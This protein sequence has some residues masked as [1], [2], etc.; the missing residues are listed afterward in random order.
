[1]KKTSVLIFLLLVLSQV[2]GQTQGTTTEETAQTMTPTQSAGSLVFDSANFSLAETWLNDNETTENVYFI[3]TTGE[4]GTITNWISNGSLHIKENASVTFDNCRFNG[5]INFY[6]YGEALLLD[7]HAVRIVTDY[8]LV[9]EGLLTLESSTVDYLESRIRVLGSADFLGLNFTGAAYGLRVLADAGSTITSGEI[10]VQDHYTAEPYNLTAKDIRG[11][12]VMFLLD[13][14]HGAQNVQI[15]NVDL[16]GTYYNLLRIGN[17]TI[18]DC[19]LFNH[20]NNYLHLNDCNGTITNFLTVPSDEYDIGIH[21]NGNSHINI[22][23][24]SLDYLVTDRPETSVLRFENTVMHDL[25]MNDFSTVHLTDCQILDTLTRYTVA[26]G[27]CFYDGYEA[28][29]DDVTVGTLTRPG[30]TVNEWQLIIDAESDSEILVRNG[31]HIKQVNGEN[32]TYDQYEGIIDHL[33][34]GRNVTGNL[35]SL[36]LLDSSFQAGCNITYTDSEL[37]GMFVTSNQENFEGISHHHLTRCSN[38][39]YGRWVNTMIFVNLTAV[40]SEFADISIGEF[41]NVDLIRCSMEYLYIDKPG[42]CHTLNLTAQDSLIRCL[43]VEEQTQGTRPRLEFHNVSVVKGWDSTTGSYEPNWWD[44]DFDMFFEDSILGEVAFDVHQIYHEDHIRIEWDA[45]AAPSSVGTYPK[46]GEY[47]VLRYEHANMDYY[48]PNLANLSDYE[49]VAITLALSYCDY[50]IEQGAFYHYIIAVQYDNNNGLW[51]DNDDDIFPAMTALQT[52]I[53]GFTEVIYWT[54]THQVPVN[55]QV[56]TENFF[57]YDGLEVQ[58]EYGT[59]PDFIG[60]TSETV[61]TIY[62]PEHTFIITV[63]GPGTWYVRGRARC[64]RIVFWGSWTSESFEVIDPMTTITTST[65]D[66]DDDDD[67][68]LLSGYLLVPCL[69]GLV[70]LNFLTRRK[71]R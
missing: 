45:S 22:S 44:V 10:L 31:L 65:F 24:S 3:G 70:A 29:D 57:T 15:T 67:G 6:N 21:L 38:D 48:T 58:L 11:I 54:N 59:D 4:W 60:A 50:D 17:L 9:Q 23:G 13:G 43:I 32:I 12:P 71:H 30:T 63:D 27:D 61:E 19:S 66:D 33:N 53:S 56:E 41:C 5:Q 8:D 16:G 20:W 40:D 69:A 47:Q 51:G 34:F 64:D 25:T 37:S 18:A 55:V 46:N 14:S 7:C 42:E 62:G 49:V 2:P 1:M 28:F 36:V 26:S 68:G 39:V 35:D 52:R